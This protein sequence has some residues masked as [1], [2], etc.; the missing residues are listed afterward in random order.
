MGKTVK[1]VALEL[2]PCCGKRSG[3]G[4]YTYELAKRLKER[5]GVWYFGNLFNFLGRNDNSTALNG[6]SIPLNESRVFPYGVYRRIWNYIPLSYDRLFSTHADLTVF[7]NYIVPPRIQGR[8]ITTVYDLTYLRYPETMD[9]RNLRRLKEGVSRS[10][11]RSDMILTISDFSKQEIM[12]LL[13]VPEQRIAVVPCAPGHTRNDMSFPALASKFGLR[14]PFVLY[15]GTIEPRKNL[16]R[17]IHSYNNLRNGRDFPFQLVLAGGNGWRDTEI[18][19]AAVDSPFSK[20]II[21]TGYISEAEKN[22][23]YKNASVLVYPSLYEG[24]GMPPLEAMQWGC[25]V[26]VSNRA[27]LPE[28]V[29]EAALLIDPSDEEQLAESILQV[30]SDK[31]LA[32]CLC[33][34]GFEQVKKFTWE[35]STKKLDAVCREVLEV[36]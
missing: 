36:S 33:E 7:F 34:K 12:E 23:L 27:S 19:Q 5:D 9:Q 2:Q 29:G 21:F 32:S 15:V 16:T 20:D 35:A 14:G 31:E 18:R 6:I 10:V 17:L 4:T 24:F 26:V 30:L 1:T 3:V 11:E 28:V 13:H 22:G 8:V 25:P